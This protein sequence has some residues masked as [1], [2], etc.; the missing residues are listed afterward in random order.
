MSEASGSCL[1]Q[2]GAIEAG[3]LPRQYVKPDKSPFAFSIVDDCFTT[4]ALMELTRAFQYEK[5]TKVN[6]V[7]KFI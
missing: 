6:F 7:L 4:A 3:H 2:L 1:G 5:D